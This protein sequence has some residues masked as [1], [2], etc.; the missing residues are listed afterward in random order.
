M[1]D[2]TSARAEHRGSTGGSGRVWKPPPLPPSSAPAPAPAT[3]TAAAAGG[4]VSYLTFVESGQGTLL[5]HWSETPV[6]GALASFVPSKPVPRFKLT[7][8][9]GRSELMRDV[10][11]D[12]RRFYQGVCSFVKAAKALGAPL[13]FLGNTLAPTAG[14]RVALYLRG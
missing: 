1:E 4:M 10:S 5:T 14:P 2:A 13:T 9:G 3:A 7:A 11:K 12:P 6:E 8:N